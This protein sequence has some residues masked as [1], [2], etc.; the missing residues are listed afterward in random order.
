MVLIKVVL[1]LKEVDSSYLTTVIILVF[2]VLDG[3]TVKFMV[4]LSMAVVLLVKRLK[5]L[6]QVMLFGQM[7]EQELDF[8]IP[9]LILIRSKE[10]TSTYL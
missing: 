1:L 3:L 10:L 7:V 6:Q 2:T 5:V 4:L 8:L 9:T